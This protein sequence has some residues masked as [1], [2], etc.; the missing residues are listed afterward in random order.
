MARR[1]KHDNFEEIIFASEQL[2]FLSRLKF[3][4]QMYFLILIIASDAQKLDILNKYL[5]II[6]YKPFPKISPRN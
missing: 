2:F 6:K 4:Y 3:S 5:N 1:S